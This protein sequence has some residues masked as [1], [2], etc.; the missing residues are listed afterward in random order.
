MTVTVTVLIPAKTAENVQTTQYTSTNVTT[1]IDKFTATNYS[2]N[3]A[4]I[5]VNLVSNGG[6]V[7]NDNLIVKTKT[8]QAGETYAFPEI[9]GAALASGG[10]IS[11]LASAA[12]SVNIRAS[13][14]V[15]TS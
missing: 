15:I 7:G 9:V 5:S 2:A 10:T 8:L 11:T 12:A 6:V 13:G 14:R 1:I 4:S 3:P